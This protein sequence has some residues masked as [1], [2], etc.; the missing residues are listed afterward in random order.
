MQD[1][2]RGNSENATSDY[3]NKKVKGITALSKE[4]RHK[5]KGAHFLGIKCSVMDQKG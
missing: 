2:L 5:L 3:S 1:D 4:R